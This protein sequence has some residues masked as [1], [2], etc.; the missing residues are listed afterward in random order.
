MPAA[1]LKVGGLDLAE[2]DEEHT[3]DERGLQYPDKTVDGMAG[4]LEEGQVGL[5]EI[6]HH[7]HHHRDR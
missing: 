7:T 4:A 3:E 1:R 2:G 5:Y 6:E